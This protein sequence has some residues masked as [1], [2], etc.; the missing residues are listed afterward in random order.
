MSDGFDEVKNGTDSSTAQRIRKNRRKACW[1]CHVEY[2]QGTL[3][4][5]W[6]ARG[7]PSKCT[8]PYKVSPSQ[9]AMPTRNTS[10]KTNARLGSGKTGPWPRR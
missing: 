5:I 2:Q 4:K 10:G 3:W 1:K 6:G 7:V 8:K 9:T